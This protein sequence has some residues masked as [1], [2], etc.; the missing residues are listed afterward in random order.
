[1]PDAST[2]STA[3]RR[4]RPA[5]D[6]PTTTSDHRHHPVKITN[7]V[8]ALTL[9]GVV[10]CGTRDARGREG[11]TPVSRSSLRPSDLHSTGTHHSF[12]KN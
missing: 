9:V 11:E 8:T 4:C 3:P 1:M 6:Q 10:M 12:A 2:P 5:T 7:R